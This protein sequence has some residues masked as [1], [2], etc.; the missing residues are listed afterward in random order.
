MNVNLK[1]E[2]ARVVNICSST[3]HLGRADYAHYV[4]A[5]AGVIGLSRAMAC[6]LDEFRIG[7][8]AIT[9]G[10]IYTEIPRA[11]VTGPRRRRLSGSNV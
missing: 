6:E 9:P 5:K 4:R 11:T 7:V 2:R 10:P 8:D 1:A 3:V